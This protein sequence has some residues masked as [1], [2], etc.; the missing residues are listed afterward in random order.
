[1]KYDDK[2]FLN[3][4]QMADFWGVSNS[5]VDRDRKCP[6][7]PKPVKI[8]RRGLRWYK[9]ELLAYTARRRK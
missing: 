8:G 9:S 5:T 7:F 3:R 4:K 1:M 6:D 2:H